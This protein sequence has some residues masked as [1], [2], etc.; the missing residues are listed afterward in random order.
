V[1]PVTFVDTSVLCELLRVP[2]KSQRP[3]EV[4]AELDQRASRGERFV[5]PVTAIIETGNHIVHAN[6]DRY[7]AAQRLC[8]LIDNIVRGDQSFLIH[9]FAWDGAFLQYLC[10]GDATG[11]RLDQWAAAGQMGTGDLAILVER[12][13]FVARSALKRNDVT[14]WTLETVM[15]GYA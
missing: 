9:E 4:R 12:D 8:G 3:D 13:R 11:Q 14:I 10:E 15:G 1:S 2:G 5:I 6:G 7:G